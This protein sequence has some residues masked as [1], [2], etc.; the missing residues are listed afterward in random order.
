MQVINR[1]G[2]GE[3]CLSPRAPPRHADTRKR[4]AVGL[5]ELNPLIARGRPPNRGEDWPSVE[6][7]TVSLTA[8]TLSASPLRS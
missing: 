4:L 5:H 7:Q 2:S 3:T 1:P 8:P 6:I